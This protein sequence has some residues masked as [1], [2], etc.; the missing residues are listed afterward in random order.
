[1]WRLLSIF[2][3]A[4]K[5]GANYSNIHNSYLTLKQ[6]KKPMLLGGLGVCV[7]DCVSLMR[8]RRLPGKRRYYTRKRLLVS[9]TPERFSW[10]HEH[11]KNVR[12]N[13]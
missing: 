4:H 8:V 6:K 9:D 7:M 10:Q 13:E 2:T 3:R 11:L 1:M 5:A 12:G